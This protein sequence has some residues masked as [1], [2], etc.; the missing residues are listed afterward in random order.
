M[1][2]SDPFA[3]PYDFIEEHK[4]KRWI[5]RVYENPGYMMDKMSEMPL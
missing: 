3:F 2:K 4:R 1:D 5:Q